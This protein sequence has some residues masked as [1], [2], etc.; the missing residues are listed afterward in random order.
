MLTGLVVAI[1][2]VQVVTL[3]GLMWGLVELR[4]M[5]KATHSIQYVPADAP[6]QKMTQ[7]LQEQ[8]TKD[9]FNNV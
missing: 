1:G 8:L 4:A 3:A 9:L 5:Q 6:F 2:V 7:E